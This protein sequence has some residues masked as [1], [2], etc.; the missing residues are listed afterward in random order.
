ERHARI[1][2]VRQVHL[3]RAVVSALSVRNKVWLDAAAQMLG[4]GCGHRLVYA[5][6]DAIVARQLDA[7]NEATAAALPDRLA[8][9]YQEAA[10]AR[11]VS[12]PSVCAMIGV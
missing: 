3:Q 5:A 9:L 4:D 8:S 10:A 7:Q 12:T 1:G 6:Q 2:A 11:E